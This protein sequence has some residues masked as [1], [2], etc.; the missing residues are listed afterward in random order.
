MGQV[1]IAGAG[2]STKPKGLPPVGTAL[3]DMT[4]EEVRM[5]SDAGKAADYFAVGDTK[6]VAVKGNIGTVG[7]DENC[8]VFIL[9]IDHNESVEGKGI[10]FGCF[11]KDFAATKNVAICFTDSVYT[12]GRV[13]G[14]K[15]Y[16]MNHWGSYNHG[17]WKSCDLRYDILGSTDIAPDQ[18]GS[19]ANYLGVGHDPSETCA[20]NPV[21]N[22]FMAALPAELR[23]VM[24][25]IT[26]YSDNTGAGSNKSSDVTVT[27]DY[28]PLLAEFEIFGTR[29]YANTYEKNY[30]KQYDY[31]KAGN[32]KVIKEFVN[33]N[34]VN[35]NTRSVYSTTQDSFCMVTNNGTISATGGSYS[36]GLAPIFMV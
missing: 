36:E 28:L 35:W 15:L 26:K 8:Y 11:K 25:P 34:P 10:T 33:G 32:S 18:Y 12:T 13:N 22:T 7:V 23:A 29:T 6:V 21:E 3:E 17:G 9:G 2:R 27:I 24:R 14:S 16:N 30:Q 19:P 31:Y 4:W 20:T 1:I 5:I